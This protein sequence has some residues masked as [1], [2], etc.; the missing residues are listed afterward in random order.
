LHWVSYS[1]HDPRRCTS[2]RTYHLHTTRQANA[3]LRTKKIKEKMK[4]SRI[5]IQ[6]LPSQ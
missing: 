1:Y 5:Q 2:C 4:L 3:I 6:T